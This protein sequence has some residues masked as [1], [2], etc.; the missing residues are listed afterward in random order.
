MDESLTT[1]SR[2]LASACIGI[3]GHSPNDSADRNGVQRSRPAPKSLHCFAPK[4]FHGPGASPLPMQ[5]SRDYITA[6]GVA[7]GN[8]RDGLPNRWEIAWQNM[9]SFRFG[10]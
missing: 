7:F 10:L 8:S 4:S 2:R 6:W 5:D 9:K 3:R 1:H